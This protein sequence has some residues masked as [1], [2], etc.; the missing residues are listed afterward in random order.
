MIDTERL[1][2]VHQLLTSNKKPPRKIGVTYYQLTCA[3]RCMAMDASYKV[4]YYVGTRAMRSVAERMMRDIW[5]ELDL[6]K[7]RL[8]ENVFGTRIYSPN[9]YPIHPGYNV[10]FDH[11]IWDKVRADGWIVSRY[12][13]LIKEYK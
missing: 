9:V 8:K 4:I 1:H 2:K 10:I 13:H 12:G 6:D 7:D 3:L 5:S 11:H